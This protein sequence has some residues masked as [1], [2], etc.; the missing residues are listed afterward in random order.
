[1]DDT[2]K[3]FYN[4]FAELFNKTG[5][6]RA[7][8][9]RKIGMDTS[10]SFYH[11]YAELSNTKDIPKTFYVKHANGANITDTPITNMQNYPV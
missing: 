5:S 1:M 8:Y 9:N 3:T 6:F 4:K 2:T 10:K 7:F 11:K